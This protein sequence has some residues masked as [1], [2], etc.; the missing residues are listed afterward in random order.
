M[1]KLLKVFG[2]LLLVIVA[3]IFFALFLR[4][5]CIISKAEAKQYKYPESKFIYWR[6][7][8][9][10]YTD[11]GT[12][13]PI[14][15]IHGFGGSFTN[16][17]PLAHQLQN[18]YRVVCL[19]LP[20][21]GL[22]DL[23]EGQTTNFKAMYADYITFMLGHLH[24][25]SVYVVGNSMGGWM[26][27]SLTAQHLD[28]VKKLVLF[29]SAGYDLDKVKKNLGVSD[30][31]KTSI[32]RQIVS[33][34]MPLF[35]SR[36]NARK[37][38]AKESAVDEREVFISNQL[39]NRNGNLQSMLKLLSSGE[40]ADTTLITKITCP[41]LI[42]WGRQDNIVPVEH[43]N[44]FKRDLPNSQLI[45]YED[46]GHVPMLEHPDRVAKDVDVFLSGQ[47]Q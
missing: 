8:E 18:K 40:K 26:S 41:T 34:G 24:M 22:S 2:V 19:D 25:D 37:I 9:I 42:I 33:R 38:R 20:G 7:A 44:R 31:L 45:I 4:P 46:C 47:P 21:F 6:G 32:A 3:M 14:M 12:G 5:S 36:K 29:N 23:P 1:K 16:M 39:A 15:F 17:E 11:T 27:W 28:K 43:A 35:I 10:H 30:F 13:P